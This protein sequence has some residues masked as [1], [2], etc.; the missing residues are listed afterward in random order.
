MTM[1]KARRTKVR[2]QP[3]L[4]DYQEHPSWSCSG[5]S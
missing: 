3:E 2:K 4:F 5:A 1:K